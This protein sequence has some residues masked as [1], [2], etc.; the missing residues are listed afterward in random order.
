MKSYNGFSATQRAAIGPYLR[1]RIR[2]GVVWHR[3]CCD[4][5]GSTEHVSGHSE[6][7][8]TPYGPH[9]GAYTLCRKCHN[10]VHNRGRLAANWDRRRTQ[11]RCL[12]GGRTTLDDIHE[13]LRYPSVEALALAGVA[14]PFTGV[15][16]IEPLRV[17]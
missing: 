13:G 1:E 7:Y 10:A 6:D 5:C 8:S 11:A 4:A 15:R 17:R 2:D 12:R 16:D 14:D 9:I 3:P